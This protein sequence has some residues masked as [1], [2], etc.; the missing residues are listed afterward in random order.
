MDSI[1]G[2]YALTRFAIALIWIYHGL[3]P[4]ILFKHASEVELVAKG[5]IIVDAETTIVIAGVVEVL[6]GLLVLVFWKQ[7]WPIVISLAGFSGL[8]LGAITLSPELA[9]QAF[10]PV[11]LTVSAIAFCLIQLQEIKRCAQPDDE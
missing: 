1:I 5:P 3:V 8:L 6:I 7:P 4:K 2:T 9:I 11:T 10:N